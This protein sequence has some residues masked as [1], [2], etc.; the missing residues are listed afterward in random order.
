[1]ELGKKFSFDKEK[2]KFR[3]EIEEMF[4][5]YNLEYVHKWEDCNFKKRRSI[6]INAQNCTKDSIVK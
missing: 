1:M 5:S 2:Y 6:Q 4:Q 3:F